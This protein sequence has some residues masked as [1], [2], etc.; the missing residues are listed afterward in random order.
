MINISRRLSLD[1]LKLVS[2]AGILFWS[3]AA[4]ADVPLTR[5]DIETLLNRVELLPRGAR[6]RPASLTDSLGQGDSLRTAAASRAE[7]RFN[8]GSLARVGQHATF[9]F[10]PNT[11]NF[12]LS[13]GTVLLLIP[14]GQGRSTIQTPNVVTGVQGTGLVVRYISAQN[15]TL[16]MALTE[17]SHGPMS[18]TTVDGEQETTLVAGQMALIQGNQIQ[19]FEFDLGAFYQTSDLIQGLHL[20]DANYKTDRV[21]PINA[22]RQETQSAL[23]NQPEFSEAVSFLDPT[24]IQ[25]GEGSVPRDLFETELAPAMVETNPA[26]INPITSS[27][28]GNLTGGEAA[29]SGGASEM[30]GISL[31]PVVNL[32]QNA[33][34]NGDVIPPIPFSPGSNAAIPAVSA[35]PNGPGNPA[36]PATPAVPASPNGPENPATP[37]APAVPA[38]AGG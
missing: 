34:P 12:R 24:W 26:G 32:P 33:A 37:A 10:V 31:P 38:S 7:L 29:L 9:R 6:P 13:N 28:V 27:A 21:D 35:S 16:V 30:N 14:P 19:V 8:D 4:L 5:A 3:Q 23:E 18:V 11:R 15:L 22:V 20:D 1:A 25:T 2:A 36:T 17:S